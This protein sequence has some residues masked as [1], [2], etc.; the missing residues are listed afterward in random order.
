[1]M[2]RIRPG[3]TTA[4]G[5]RLDTRG[6]RMTGLPEPRRG[7]YLSSVSHPKLRNFLETDHE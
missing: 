5:I 4:G 6:F 3:D 7:P 1:M 2:A